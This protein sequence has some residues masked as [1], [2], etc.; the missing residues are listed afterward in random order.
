MRTILTALSLFLVIPPVTHGSDGS[1]KKEN[2]DSYQKIV[3]GAVSDVR[4]VALIGN[5]PATIEDVKE[6]S[7]DEDH[8]DPRKRTLLYTGV[9]TVDKTIKGKLKPG[10]KVIVTW[11]QAGRAGDGG[12]MT[13]LSACPSVTRNVAK[14]H[15]RVFGL[16]SRSGTYEAWHIVDG[17]PSIYEAKG[18]EPRDPFRP[19]V[20]D[21][22]PKNSGSNSEPDKK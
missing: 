3:I 20:E 19:Q 4:V 13:I 2:E 8:K 14:G 21:K 9:L 18:P 12:L 10:E 11:S 6:S 16:I 5:L 1:F 15:R 17:S 7:K 22:D